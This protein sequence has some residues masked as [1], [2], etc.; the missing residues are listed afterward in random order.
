MG[1]RSTGE[2]GDGGGLHTRSGEEGADDDS[3]ACR[4]DSNS[5]EDER[6][7]GGTVVSGDSVRDAC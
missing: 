6:S 1:P 2:G 5:N 4:T 3:I 7:T